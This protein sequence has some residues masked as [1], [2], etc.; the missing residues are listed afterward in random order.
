MTEFDVFAHLLLIDRE[1]AGRWRR[2][3]GPRAATIEVQPFRTLTKTETAAVT[4]AVDRYGTFLRLPVTMKVTPV[5]FT[6]SL[7]HGHRTDASGP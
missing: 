2:E 7:H 6:H 4:A 1:L 3:T 5:A